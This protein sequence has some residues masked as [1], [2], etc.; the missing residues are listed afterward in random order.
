M[1]RM[2]RF[3]FLLSTVAFLLLLLFALNVSTQHVGARV[4]AESL[5]L[6]RTAI[7]RAS[8]ECYALE[9]FYPKSLDYLTE[10]YGVA[11]DDGQYFVDY[12]YLGSNLMPEVMVLPTGGGVSAYE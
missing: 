11:V 1:K 12:R 8:V 6:L 3:L 10:H 4:S 9:G 5:Q 2:K 7:T